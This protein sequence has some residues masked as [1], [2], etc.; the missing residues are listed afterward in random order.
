MKMPNYTEWAWAITS[1]TY[2]ENIEHRIARSLK[3]AFDQGR[4]LGRLEGYDDGR[5]NSWWKEQEDD[6]A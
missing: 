4:A 6:N 2:C 1:E 3:D 5:D